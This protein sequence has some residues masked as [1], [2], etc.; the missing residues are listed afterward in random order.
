M[1][2][3]EKISEERHEQLFIHRISIEQ[4]A[5]YNSEGQLA[6]GARGITLADIEERRKAIPNNWEVPL[7]EKMIAKDYKSR[8]AIA[9]A[10]LAAEI[11]RLNFKPIKNK[12]QE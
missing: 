9:G 4:D 5:K 11:D 12:K 3:A 6:E 7:W 1:T 10:L 8:V 2:G